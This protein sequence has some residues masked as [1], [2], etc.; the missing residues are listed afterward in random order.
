V[1]KFVTHTWAY[2]HVTVKGSEAVG[3]VRP[4]KANRRSLHS[5]PNEQTKRVVPHLRR[6]TACLWTQPFRAGLIFDAGP[7]GLDCKHRFPMFIPPLTCRQ[8]SRLLEM[9]ILFGHRIP[10]SQEGSCGFLLVLTQGLQAPFA[11]GWCEMGQ[12]TVRDGLVQRLQ[13][14]CHVAIYPPRRRQP[15]PGWRS[16]LVSGGE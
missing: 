5:G 1:D 2:C 6:S 15:H 4:P 14:S 7:L 10:R 3:V 13:P 11:A 8:A 9:T 12:R 16:L